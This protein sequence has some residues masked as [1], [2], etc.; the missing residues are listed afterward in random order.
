MTTSTRHCWNN[1]TERR[2][3]ACESPDGNDRTEKTC[4]ND[5]GLVKITVHAP[6]GYPYRKWR[7]PTG[8]EFQVDGTPP[9][10]PMA[11]PELEV[12]SESSSQVIAI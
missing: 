4:A 11:K 3:P 6:E 12:A 10:T 9:C 7:L 2:I 5:C 1:G 8:Q